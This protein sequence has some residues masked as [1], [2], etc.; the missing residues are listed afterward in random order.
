MNLALIAGISLEQFK[1][2]IFLQVIC[3]R[4]LIKGFMHAAKI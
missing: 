4:N 2:S 3:I 1:D